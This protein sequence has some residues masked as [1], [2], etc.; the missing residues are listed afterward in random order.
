M[1]LSYPAAVGKDAVTIGVKQPIAA[2][3]SL[4]KGFYAKTVTFTLTATQP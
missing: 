1:L 4:L 3:E 2:T